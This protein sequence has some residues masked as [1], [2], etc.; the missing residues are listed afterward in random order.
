MGVQSRVWEFWS[1]EIGV[2]F[3]SSKY[4]SSEIGVMYG[5]VGVWELEC[6]IYITDEN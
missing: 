2:E 6:V 1:S 3:W 4:G 5:S